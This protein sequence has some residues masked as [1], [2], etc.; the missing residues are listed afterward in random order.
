MG[1]CSAIPIGDS[2]A[3]RGGTAGED[4]PWVRSTVAQECLRAFSEELAKEDASG[5]AKDDLEQGMALV[6]QNVEVPES[7]DAARRPIDLD[8][9]QTPVGPLGLAVLSILLT[10]N[11]RIRSLRLARGEKVGSNIAAEIGRSLRYNTMLET[12]DF[13]GCVLG[14]KGVVR[15]AKSIANPKHRSADQSLSTLIL[16]N[17]GANDEASLA[18]AQLM[19]VDTKLACLEFKDNALTTD[20][21]IA[22]RLA[23]RANGRLRRLEFAGEGFDLRNH[24]IEFLL[25][26]NQAVS[27][28]LDYIIDRSTDWENIRSHR[29]GSLVA[30]GGQG[31]SGV[32]NNASTSALYRSDCMPLGGTCAGGRKFV[33]GQAETVGKRQEMQD[34]VMMKSCFRGRE[35]EHLFGVFDGKSTEH[36]SSCGDK[37]CPSQLPFPFQ[38]VLV[39][40][41][42]HNCALLHC[43]DSERWNPYGVPTLPLTHNVTPSYP[44]CVF[45]NHVLAGHG[46]VEC[47]RFVGANF[48]KFF[49]KCLQKQDTLMVLPEVKVENAFLETFKLLNDQV[50]SLKIPYGC[51]AVVCFIQVCK[52]CAA[53]IPFTVNPC[54]V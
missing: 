44:L 18:L 6:L 20:S 29:M 5:N 17:V 13:T 4:E 22:F 15:L 23:L 42:V 11:I 48:P 1:I 9:S 54:R 25:T 16:N 46:G 43:L 8:L 36:I 7:Y 38:S 34:V 3:L 41:R 21:L 45:L 14:Q 35:D 10:N 27:E 37:K 47:A 31:E 2:S 28:A 12:L 39:A 30:I 33:F 52:T 53:D 24:E 32:G 26:R 40:C 19:L 50:E 49:E 51:C